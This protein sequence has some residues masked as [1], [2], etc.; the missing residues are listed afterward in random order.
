MDG[1]N[2][3]NCKKSIVRVTELTL[4][5][6]DCFILLPDIVNIQLLQV[7][8][9]DILL[10]FVHRKI[11]LLAAISDNQILQVTENRYDVLN[12]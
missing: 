5:Y 8:K 7:I 6:P 10:F 12:L 4:F 9:R 11:L 1:A 2:N 3:C